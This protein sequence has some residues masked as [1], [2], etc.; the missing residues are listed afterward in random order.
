[1]DEDE[2]EE[3]GLTV[4][5]I[6]LPLYFRQKYEHNDTHTRAAR[7]AHSLADLCYTAA[8]DDVYTTNGVSLPKLPPTPPPAPA[9][10]PPAPATPTTLVLLLLL[11]LLPLPLLLFP[12]LLLLQEPAQVRVG[13]CTIVS[14]QA[15]GADDDGQPRAKFL[16][17]TI[18]NTLTRK[19]LRPDRGGRLV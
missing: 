16:R 10:P 5:K 14:P 8:R 18:A 7:R 2:D 11:L 3:S 19:H 4:L 6:L 13:R 15:T 1:M 12:L 9:T 17:T